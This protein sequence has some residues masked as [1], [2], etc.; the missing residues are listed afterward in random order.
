MQT[1]PD[2]ENEG[3][4]LLFFYSPRDVV[5]CTCRE[6]KVSL[7]CDLSLWMHARQTLKSES[8]HTKSE[9]LHSAHRII[10]LDGVM[11]K[12]TWITKE[13]ALLKDENVSRKIPG[14]I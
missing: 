2:C 6:S 4:A 10:A 5:H 14:I 3:A 7:R 1:A 12:Y 8:V 11:D 13:R 9:K